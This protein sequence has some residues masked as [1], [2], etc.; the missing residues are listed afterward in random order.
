MV[1]EFLRSTD[2][3]HCHAAPLLLLHISL[4][5]YVYRVTACMKRIILST[6]TTALLGVG[7]ELYVLV[8]ADSPLSDTLVIYARANDIINFLISVFCNTARPFDITWN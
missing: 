7:M 6:P 1:Y 5:F 4:H 2:I 3:A 8:E